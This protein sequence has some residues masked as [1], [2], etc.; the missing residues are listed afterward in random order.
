[1]TRINSFLAVLAV[2][3]MVFSTMAEAR[4]GS[5]GGGGHSF[6]SSRS[7]SSPSRSYS[8]PSYTAPRPIVRN[9]TTVVHQTVVHQAAPSSGGGM[10]SGLLMGGALGYLFGNHNSAP[11]PAP[12]AQ[13][14]VVQCVG[15][16]GKP[17][18]CPQSQADKP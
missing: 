18:V 10:F 14:Q 13:P 12:V 2:V 16:D 3:L 17:L 8:R 15:T 4:G 1:M 7:F 5:F 11:A 6:S 9:N